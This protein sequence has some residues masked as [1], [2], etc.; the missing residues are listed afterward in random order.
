[1]HDF[2]MARDL[3]LIASMHQGGGP[4]RTPDGWQRL[5]AAGLLGDACQ[6]RPWTRPR[7]QPAAAL[8]RARHEL[9]GR[10]G[11]RNVA[12]PRSSADRPA[13]PLRARAVAGRGLGERPERR[14]ADPGAHRARHPAQP[15]QRRTPGIA[16]H[17]S[18]DLHHHH[19]RGAFLGDT[20][21][22]ADAEAGTSHRIACRRQAGG[23]GHDPC[24]GPQHAAGARSGQQRGDAGVA[25]QHRQRDG[26]RSLEEAR[27]PP[28]RRRPG[29]EARAAAVLGPQDRGRLV[30]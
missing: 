23:P 29:A 4:A 26:R 18:A 21:G 19:A 5:E 7:R 10:G 6:H 8:L 22:G 24:P 13:A 16:R 12:R 17:D 2:R 14:H 28:G 11:E 9:F 27:R 20:G 15:G 1:M 25:G 3:G 30:S